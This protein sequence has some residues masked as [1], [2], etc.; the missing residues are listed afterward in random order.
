MPVEPNLADFEETYVTITKQRE[1]PKPLS[2]TSLTVD[3]VEMTVDGIL[4]IAFSKPILPLEFVKSSELEGED[5]S[6]KPER[7]LQA[8][9]DI[10]DFVELKVIDADGSNEEYIE[11]DKDMCDISFLSMAP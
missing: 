1:E 7:R 10:N 6:S 3:D 11:F 4:T 8:L 2:I 9:V 5:T